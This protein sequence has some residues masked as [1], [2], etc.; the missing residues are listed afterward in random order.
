M[1]VAFVHGNPETAAV[2]GPLLARLA[3]MGRHDTV[4]LSPP[5]FGAPVPDGFGATSDDYLEWL[6]GALAALGAPGVP[7]DLV[8][9]DWGGGHVIRLACTRPDLIRSWASDI[10]GC[11]APDYV[12]HDL[13]QVWQADGAGEEAVA[14][15]VTLPPAERAAVL[16]GAGMTPEVAADVA[17]NID[18]ANARCVLSLYRSAAQPAMARW[19]ELLPHAAAR[20]GLVII[21][22]AD[23]YT[24]GPDRARWAA[25]QAGARIAELPDLGHWWMLQDPAAGAAV[26]EAFWT[27]L[28]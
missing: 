1:T 24:G 13:A 15:M 27:T 10:G 20:A 7:V 28:S 6:A 5:G 21:P 8:G 19:G 17:A 22:T 9:H 25:G 11:F 3:E 18:E 14:A 26:L 12:W 16:E 4:T 2:W 23:P